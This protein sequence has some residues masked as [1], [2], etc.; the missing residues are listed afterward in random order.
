MLPPI[1]VNAKNGKMKSNRDDLT[2]PLLGTQYRGQSPSLVRAKT[3]R[4][5]IPSMAKQ[6]QKKYLWPLKMQF[7]GH[8]KQIA[9]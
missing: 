1:S 3:L 4:S 8:N 7:M 6:K 5:I 9:K 2:K